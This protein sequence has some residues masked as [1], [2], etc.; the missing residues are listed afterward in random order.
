MKNDSS[1]GQL[2]KGMAAGHRPQLPSSG[3]IWWRAQI[4]RKQ[5]EKE[6]IERPLIV[7]RHVAA[8]TSGAVLATL[9][10]SNLAR[11][12]TVIYNNNWFLMP[13]LILTATAAVVSAA[14]PL[15]S[16]AKK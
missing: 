13:L 6:R 2:L 5:K 4:Y 10:A 7:M 8:I 15:W 9:V 16:R 1:L 3:L 12:K 11:M 14:L